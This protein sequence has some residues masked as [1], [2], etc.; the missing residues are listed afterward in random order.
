MAQPRSQ[1][2]ERVQGTDGIRREV[3]PQA[4]FPGLSPQAVFLRHG[5]LTDEF[6]E[7]YAFAHVS[8]LIQ[9]KEAKVGDGFVIGWDPRDPRGRFTEAVVRG[10]RKAGLQAWV[11]GVVPTPLVPLFVLA[12]RAAGGIM[13]T[14]SHNPPEHN[15]IKIFSGWRGMKSLPENDRLLTRA[16]WSQASLRNRKLRGRRLDYRKEALA[17]FHEF[18]SHPLNSWGEGLSFEDIILVVDPARGSLAGIA[19]RQF[20]AAGFG[21]VHEVN[22]RQDGRVNHR[23]GVADLEGVPVVTSEMIRNGGR[24]AGYPA[25]VKLFELGRRH[26]RALQRGTRKVCGAVFDAD[27]DRFYRLDYHPGRDVLLVLSGDETAF[28]Q[29]RFLLQR[30]PRRYRGARYLHTVESDLNCG[31]AA[32]RLGLKREVTPVGDKWILWRIMRRFLE[33]RL[34]GLTR[35]A[36]RH[37]KA[38]VLKSLKA[39]QSRWRRFLKQPRWDVRA[40]RDLGETLD[41]IEQRLPPAA[42]RIPEVEA[43]RLAVGSEETGHNITTGWLETRPN[44]FTPVHAG[45][46]LKSALN[47]FAAT[48]ALLAGRNPARYYASL[49]APFERGHKATFYAYHIDQSRFRRGSALWRKL[50]RTVQDEVR[51]LGWRGRVRRFPEDPDMWY[52][53]LQPGPSAP[54]AALFVRNSGT[55]NKISVNVRGGRKQAERLNALGETVLCFLMREMKDPAHPLFALEREL[56]REMD[57][58]PRPEHRMRAGS[59]RQVLMALVR[60]GLVRPSAGGYGPTPLGRWYLR[61]AGE[62]SRVERRP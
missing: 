46:G 54:E 13:V 52:L 56:L 22:Q 3:R 32:E 34:S 15:G 57:E 7:R 6:L 25:L 30:D 29:A 40:L 58:R 49:E 59:S 9:T 21:E 50:Q 41:R 39:V 26:R 10:V 2:P 12:R 37:G 11:I 38:A 51:K 60:Q 48:Q 8:G 16:V 45:N 1:I 19:A 24:F 53:A 20:R 33:A 43:F 27:G 55:E 5:F 4:L 61:W 31:R 28:L 18:H 36:R 35:R 23:S 44:V 17:L 62:T 47:T 14:A 42:G